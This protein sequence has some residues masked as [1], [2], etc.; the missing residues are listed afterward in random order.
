M[1]R[2]SLG[3]IGSGKTLAEVREMKINFSGRPTYTNILT[4][5]P[6]QLNLKRNM[7]INKIIL[8]TTKKRSGEVVE[9]FKLEVNEKF[10][11]KKRSPINLVIDEAHTVLNS[12]KAMTRQNILMSDWMSLMRR[13]LGGKGKGY[14][15]FVLITQF[16]RRLDVNAKDMCQQVRWHRYMCYKSCQR[17]RLTW[18][19]D[20]D[21]PEQFNYCRRCKCQDLNIWNEKIKVFY[22]VN[23][24]NFEEWRLFNKKQPFKI[25]MIH[26]IKKYY[27]LYDTL[28]WDDLLSE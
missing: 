13:I 9:N 14:G 26:G 5:I 4:S 24:L 28:Q 3:N 27:G 6:T 12:R 18:S 25:M 7:I 8:G 19:E 15:D 23:W 11:K 20:S 16:P 21:M 17:C 2:L 10:W 1:I 22:F